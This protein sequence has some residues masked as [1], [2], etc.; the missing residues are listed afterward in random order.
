MEDSF[1]YFD[2]ISIDFPCNHSLFRAPF[3]VVCVREQGLFGLEVRQK[4]VAIC[5]F[6]FI[7]RALALP[8]PKSAFL[9]CQSEDAGGSVQND[10]DEYVIEL[11]RGDLAVLEHSQVYE[12]GRYDVLH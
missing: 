4:P 12:A 6:W 8:L 2:K 10:L 11:V 9:G 5:P 7:Q 1:R 3:D